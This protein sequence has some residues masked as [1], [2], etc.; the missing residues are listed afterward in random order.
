[1]NHQT[2]RMARYL[3][4]GALIGT[5]LTGKAQANQANDNDLGNA[6]KQ[7]AEAMK[8]CVEPIPP[9]YQRQLDRWYKANSVDGKKSLEV[10]W[11]DGNETTPADGKVGPGD[12]LEFHLDNTEHYPER[13]VQYI[14][15]RI[16]QNEQYDVIG[17]IFG[18]KFETMRY[19]DLIKKNV[20][21]ACKLVS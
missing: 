16:N 11:I 19:L 3:G 21:L 18:P 14:V 1:M 7:V 4:L 2:T 12:Q 17:Y 8:G 13:Y 15:M 10:L 5:L 6:M 9:V 20:E